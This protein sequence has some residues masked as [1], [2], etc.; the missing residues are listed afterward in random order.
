M[1]LFVAKRSQPKTFAK[2]VGFDLE[3][4]LGACLKETEKVLDDGG[5]CVV[6]VE[7]DEAFPVNGGC[8]DECRLLCVVDEVPGVNAC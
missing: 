5:S 4:V 1:Y 8:V 3:G 2:N 7:V 6:A